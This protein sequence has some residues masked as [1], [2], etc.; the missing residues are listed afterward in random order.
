MVG[1]RS[2]SNWN[3]GEL[4]RHDDA[5]EG[6]E[7][8]GQ[9]P[10]NVSVYGLPYYLSHSTMVLWPVRSTFDS[11]GNGLILKY[12]LIRKEYS[13]CGPPLDFSLPPHFTIFCS[14]CT[15]CMHLHLSRSCSDTAS[16][17]DR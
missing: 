11:S 9:R 16:V 8:Q 4:A 17:S 2:P 15:S 14:Y 10:L 7:V 12:G 1:H 6:A 13:C 5:G 3:Y